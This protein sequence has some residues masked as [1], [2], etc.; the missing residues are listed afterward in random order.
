LYSIYKKG[1]YIFIRIE[2][3]A[4]EI[5]RETKLLRNK[6]VDDAV[7]YL[8]QVFWQYLTSERQNFT[9]LDFM[10]EVIILG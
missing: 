1:A 7:L 5:R 9:Q 6:D 2:L 4:E 10:A 3:P 8:K